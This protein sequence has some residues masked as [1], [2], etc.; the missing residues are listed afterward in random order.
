M[1][2]TTIT[3]TMQGYMA[4]R[5]NKL[6]RQSRKKANLDEREFRSEQKKHSTR[7]INPQRFSH[8]FAGSGQRRGD[9]EL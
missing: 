1:G 7:H 2:L 9:Y 3:K 6:N 8:K 5:K 4:Q